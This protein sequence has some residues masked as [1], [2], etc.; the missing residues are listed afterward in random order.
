MAV[1]TFIFMI[2][3]LRTNVVF[4]FLFA[5]IMTGFCL[6]AGC[7][8]HLGEMNIEVAERLKVVR[9]RPSLPCL[10]CEWN[11]AN[12]L[13]KRLPELYSSSRI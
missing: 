11:E 4:V 6:L 5:C 8:W 3:A 1:P 12:N 2:C 13:D 9:F 10:G 7:Y